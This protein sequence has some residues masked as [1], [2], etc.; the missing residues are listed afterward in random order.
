MKFIA[1]GINHSR[2]PRIASIWWMILR[3][4]ISRGK[5]RI[6]FLLK[7]IFGSGAPEMPAVSGC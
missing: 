7:R 1:G 5:N 3:E 6:R 2:S 4:K